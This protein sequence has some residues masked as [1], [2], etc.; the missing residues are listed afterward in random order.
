MA[1]CYETDRLL[2]RILT[3]EDAELVLAFCKD[4]RE[5]FEK[6]E[7]LKDNSFYTL[8]YQKASLSAEKNL[9]A[10]GKLLRY[11]IFRKDHPEEIIGSVCFQNILREPYRSCSLGYKLSFRHRHQGYATESLKKCIEIAFEEQHFHRI[12]AFIMESNESS[13]HVIKRLGFQYEGL[14]CSFARING[15]WTDHRRYALINPHDL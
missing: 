4:N 14:S 12:E 9:M 8:S 2:L 6:W 7:P 10:D 5:C 3:K 13:L 1:D 11:W 15:V